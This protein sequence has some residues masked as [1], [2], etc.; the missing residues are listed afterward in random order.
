M[1]PKSKIPGPMKKPILLYLTTLALTALCGGAAQSAP[2][3]SKYIL[4]PKPADTPRINGAR[5][6]G[7]RPG[8]E[9]LYTIAATGVRPMTFS[10]EGLPQGLKLDPETGRIT[11]RVTAP[12]EY[13][14]HLKAANA[15]GSCERNLKI[16]VGDEIALTPPMGWN[17]WNCWARDVTQ[18]QVLS[19]ARAMVESGLAD[20]GWS[21]INIDDGWQG[22]RGGKH[23]AIQPNTKFPDMKGLVREIHDM[24]LRVGIYSTPWI[25]TYAAHI[26]SYSDNPDGVNEWIKKGRHN[27]HY[28]YQKEGGNYWKDRT[29]V[30]HLGPYSFVEADVKQWGEWGIDYLKYDWNPLDYYHVKEMHDALRTLDRDVVYSLSNSAPYGDAPQ[31]MRYSN[32]WRTTGDIRDTWESISSIGF[33]QDRWLPFNRPG[34]WADPDMLVIGMVGWGPKLHYTQLTADEQYTHI[35]LWSLLAAPLLIGCD[36]AQMDDFTRSLLTNDEVIDVNQDPLGLQA[37]PVW[38]QGDQVIYV[39]HLEDGSMAVGLFNRGWQTVKMNFTLRMLGLRGRQTVRDLWRQKDLTEC[40]DKFETA[41]APHGVVLVRV[42]PGNSREQATG[43]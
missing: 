40:T 3:M 34:H 26:G 39:K 20:H 15:P 4:T 2:D 23:N 43:K 9:F 31:W 41:V 29:E 24:G 36:M 37:V 14:V 30:W 42:Y 38:Q 6:F 8:S 16:V 13:T 35:S 17:S 10:A 25:G 7:V 11:G 28:R 5:V 32:C 21:Y 12:G 27:E 18:E 19:S 1:N 33:S 22:K